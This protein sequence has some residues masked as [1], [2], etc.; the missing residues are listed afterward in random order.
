MPPIDAIHKKRKRAKGAGRPGVYG[1]NVFADFLQEAGMNVR[2][3]YAEAEAQLVEYPELFKLIPSY[4]M[5]YDLKAG[6]KKPENLSAK[7]IKILCIL[8]GAT[9]NDFI[10]NPLSESGSWDENE[11]D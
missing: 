4:S 3:F 11:E 1:S 5:L 6:K 10:T 9:P 2:E 7:N 8:I